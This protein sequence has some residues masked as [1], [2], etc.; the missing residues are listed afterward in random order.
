MRTPGPISAG[1]A[2]RSAE[3]CCSCCFVRAMWGWLQARKAEVN[4]NSKDDED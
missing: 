4:M 1:K 3:A 2:R